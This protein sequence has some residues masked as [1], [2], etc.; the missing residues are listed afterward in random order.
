MPADIASII[1]LV[2]A[3]TAAG[4]FAGLLAGL[5]GVGGGI[6]IVPALFHLFSLLEV[7]E[8][9]KMH[10]A[11]GTSLATII[12]TSLSSI[13]AHAKRGAVDWSILKGWG[14]WIA[15][16]VAAGTAIA[17]SVSGDALSAVFA[18]VALIVAVYMAFAPDGL[19]LASQP[20]RGP[21]RAG[22]AGLIGAISAM[23]GIGGGTLTVPTLVLSSVP[24]HRAVGT[25]AAVGLI[26]AVPG[27]IGFIIAGWGAAGLPWGSLGYV[28][29]LGFAVIVPTTVAVAPLGARL[30]HAI[31]KVLLRR[32]FAL[33]LAITALRM[34]YELGL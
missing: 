24:V 1:F 19:R 7:A 21:A 18:A 5:L 9:V 8:A 30:A 34:F 32:L 23:M 2:A 13:R 10:L 20:P 25:A 28:S 15:V 22:I 14:P 33:F 27:A 29:V 6:V 4:A 12:A 11:V 26:I 16:G 3:L 31:D 17:A